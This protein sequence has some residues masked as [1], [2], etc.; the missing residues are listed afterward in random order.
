MP[1]TDVAYSRPCDENTVL[2]STMANASIT[3][4]CTVLIQ[5]CIRLFLIVDNLAIS[6][7]R[8]TSR[9]REAETH[10]PKGYPAST[11]RIRSYQRRNTAHELIRACCGCRIIC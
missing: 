7:R 1:V 4:A 6:Q 10:G 8:H 11:L 2:L 3:S 5:R 9:D